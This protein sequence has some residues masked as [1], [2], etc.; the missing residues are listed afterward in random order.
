MDRV[1]DIFS[2]NAFT[3]VGLEYRPSL[4]ENRIKYTE[5]GVAYPIGG[6]FK[7]FQV[8][9]CLLSSDPSIVPKVKN[10]RIIAVPE[11]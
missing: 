6:S 9:V 10:L 11:G 8:K 7:N 5:N 1:K 3:L 4:T 2:R